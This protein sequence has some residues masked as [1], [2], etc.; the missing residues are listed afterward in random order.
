MSRWQQTKVRAPDMARCYK[1]GADLLPF[2]KTWRPSGLWDAALGITLNANDVSQIDHQRGS[3]PW[4]SVP[5][6]LI[7]PA[8]ANQPLYIGAPIYNGQPSIQFT[9]ANADRLMLTAT[10]LIGA[11][12]VTMFCVSRMR[13]NVSDQNIF[14][15]S[16]NG[17]AGLFF[18]ANSAGNRDWE[19]GAVAA[20]VD[21]AYSTALAEIWTGVD[22]SGLSPA[23][24]YANGNPVTISNP[25]AIHV[26]P[27]G[28][29][30]VYIGALANGAVPSDV[31]WMF[32][33]IYVFALNK[34]IITRLTKAAK[35][36]FGVA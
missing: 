32:G 8:G 20:R 17:T 29:G 28:T 14:G 6:H 25:N 34:N 33:A 11:G 36:R 18:R 27:G 15:N 31:D 19:A 7:Q 35:V 3:R 9:A 30:A 13:T 21:G 24:L 16:T 22:F 2:A 5:I 10:D 26:A 4:Q 12:F 23:L 1:S